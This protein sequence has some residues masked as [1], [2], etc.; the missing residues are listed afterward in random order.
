MSNP[1]SPLA[2]VT[3]EIAGHVLFHFGRGG[4]PTSGFKTSLL[5]A[6]AT[7][8]VVNRALLGK[9]FPGYEVAFNLAQQTADGIAVLSR[10]ADSES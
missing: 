9:G 7:A 1:E 8:D 5:Q 3:P 6:F 4:W 10:I 2:A